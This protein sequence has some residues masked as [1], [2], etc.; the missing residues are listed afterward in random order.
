[1]NSN[2]MCPP[3]VLSDPRDVTAAIQ[4][5]AGCRRLWLDTEVADWWDPGRRR[6]SLIQI[7][8]DHV[9][10][11]QEQVLLLDVLDQSPLIELFI[12]RVM[13]NAAVEKVFHNKAFDVGYLGGDRA[14]TVRCTLQM[15]K[16][17]RKTVSLPPQ[18]T[19][20][21]LAEHFELAPAVSKTEQKSNWG[22]RPLTDSQLRYAALDVIYLWGIDQSL[23]AASAGK[24]NWRPDAVVR[25]AAAIHSALDSDSQP[26]VPAPPSA[27]SQAFALLRSG[28]SLDDVATATNRA[29][30]TVVGYLCEFIEQERITDPSRWLPIAENVSQRIQGVVRQVGRD[31][32]KPI[33]EALNEEVS[34]DAIRVVLA[35]SSR[36]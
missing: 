27:R 13:M 25:A 4:R 2:G 14:V 23:A 8:P 3:V 1:M 20:Q 24:Q 16:A 10:V 19:L 22:R 9:P 21:S 28:A 30:S 17:L 36:R 26:T 35:C 12:R 29:R 6:L 34:Y 33:Y 15:A 5:M 18:L 11:E 7:L 31:K 32:L